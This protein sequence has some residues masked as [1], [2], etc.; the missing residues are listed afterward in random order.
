MQTQKQSGMALVLALLVVAIVTA[1]S[2]ELSWRFDLAITR[3]ENRWYGVQ[4]NAY[5]MG[6]EEIAYMALKMDKEQD[7]ESERG[8]VDTLEEFWSTQAAEFAT[9]EGWLSGRLEDA[10]G[11]FNLNQLRAKVDD[12]ARRS[13]EIYKHF[14]EPQ[15]RFIR[16]LQ[17]VNLGD[18][19]SPLYL[20][21][22]TAQNI[23]EAVIDWLDNDSNV[24]GFGGAESD[25]YGQ[26]EPPFSVPNGLMAS[27]TELNLIRGMT[28]ALYE[29][30]LPLV[31][32]LPENQPLNVNTVPVEILRTLNR[33]DDLYP[34]SIEDGDVFVQ[35]RGEYKNVEDFVADAKQF[36]PDS[37]NG[38]NNFVADGLGVFTEYFIFYGEIQMGEHVRTSKALLYRNGTEVTTIRRTD[39]NF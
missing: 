12:K 20:D 4:A 16:L 26:L 33:Q 19:E 30:L 7:N 29:K 32:A 9:D 6:A 38:K 18:E 1:I 37:D 34:L 25:F 15:R 36:F 24:T 27:V 35:N 11:R 8:Q 13:A 3:A 17:C 23:T 22:T 5:L 28:P 10:Q 2:V 39:A 31:I 21:V 14:T